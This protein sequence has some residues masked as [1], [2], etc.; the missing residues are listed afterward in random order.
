M[1]SS[2]LPIGMRA[3]VKRKLRRA[4]ADHAPESPYLRR[5]PTPA[6]QTGGGDTLFAGVSFGVS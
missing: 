6:G 1:T 5:L 3:S 2:D 4:G